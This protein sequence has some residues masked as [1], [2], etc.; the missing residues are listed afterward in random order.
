[1]AEEINRRVYRMLKSYCVLAD[2]I[3]D[4]IRESFGQ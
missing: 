3:Y 2:R 4:E 1:M